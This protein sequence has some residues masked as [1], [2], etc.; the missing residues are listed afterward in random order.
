MGFRSAS[1]RRELLKSTAGASAVGLAGCLGSLQGDTVSIDFNTVTGPDAIQGKVPEWFAE[2]VESRTDTVEVEVFFDSELGGL[3]ESH[4]YMSDGSLDMACTGLSIAG[5]H[6]PLMQVFG[7]P[8]MYEDFEHVAKA[9]DPTQTDATDEIVSGLVDESDI[10]SLGAVVQGTRHVTLSDEPAT[11]PEDLSG[12]T[13]RAV[14]IDIYYETVVGL[15]AEATNID[16]SELP[17]ALA[18]GSVD[19]QENPYSLIWDLGIYENQ[20]YVIETGHIIT[21]L[22]I[23]ISEHTWSELND[24]QQNVFYEAVSEIQPR[25]IDWIRET[26]SS[27]KSDIQDEG[28]EIF[29]PSDIELDA[30]RDKVR[31]HIADTFPDWVEHI[32]AVSGSSYS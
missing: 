12:R 9:T 23:F 2:E 22:G 6:Y 26:E 18:T 19:G 5:T 21:P 10:R 11:K 4:D 27:L 31:G 29:E 7:A 28:L 32:E 24:E 20:D 15:G 3:I 25:A 1:S 8:Y 14:P 17:T 13:L 16:L 30:F